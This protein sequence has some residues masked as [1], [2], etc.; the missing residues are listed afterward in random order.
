MRK[1]YYY[2]TQL[3]IVL[4]DDKMS[5]NRLSIKKQPI[6]FIVDKL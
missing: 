2:T 1:K 6:N 5:Q 4:I 3:C